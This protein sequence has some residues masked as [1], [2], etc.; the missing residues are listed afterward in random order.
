MLPRVIRRQRYS[1][2]KVVFIVDTSASNSQGIFPSLYLETSQLHG[3][4]GAKCC[5]DA[6][7]IDEACISK[8]SQTFREYQDYRQTSEKQEQTA[9]TELDMVEFW[10]NLYYPRWSS[11]RVLARI[12]R[13]LCDTMMH[14]SDGR[15]LGSLGSMLIIVH[16][17]GVHGFDVYPCDWL[18]S[19]YLVD[20]HE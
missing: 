4:M 3:A 2:F 5:P 8:V 9:C 14:W 20:G 18:P 1:D 19:D 11:R 16:A 15:R 13:E 6:Q 17:S 10:R 7:A 12:R